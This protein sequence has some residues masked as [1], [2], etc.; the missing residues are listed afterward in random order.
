ME[1]SKR[2]LF[3]G[4]S[5]GKKYERQYFGDNEV[6]QQILTGTNIPMSAK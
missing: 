3:T 5:D 6:Y 1:Y 4:T 2:W